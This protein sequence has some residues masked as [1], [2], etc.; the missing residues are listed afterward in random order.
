MVKE[1]RIYVEGGGNKDTKG[2][3]RRGFS[4][5]FRQVRDPARASKIRWQIIVCGPR[6]T[7]YRR[8][9][10][11]IT[12]AR[13]VFAILLVD[14]EASVTTEP[15]GHLRANDNWACPPRAQQ[16]NCHLMVQLMEAWFVADL[17]ALKGF[18]GTTQFM[19]S[20]IPVSRDIEKI[21][22]TTVLNALNQATRESAK[23]PYNKV[24]HAHQLL[25][26]IEEY[27]VR[28]KSRH[29]DRL[30][31]VLEDIVKGRTG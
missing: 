8:F 27:V 15:W 12:D 4:E 29:C 7:A 25:Q 21:E 30:F 1:I 20:A 17:E 3:L 19:A 22:K 13:D 9:R 14:S 10:Q 5:F 24:L 23:G 26:V 16:E 2:F 31:R 28:E 6:A 11:C 18:Y